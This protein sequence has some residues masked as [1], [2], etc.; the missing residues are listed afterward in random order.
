MMLAVV[1]KCPVLKC[2]HLA[3]DRS[4]GQARETSECD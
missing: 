2:C 1:F 3:D 4:L